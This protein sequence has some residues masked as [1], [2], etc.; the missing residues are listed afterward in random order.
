MSGFVLL[1]NL[2]S[3]GISFAAQ[4][5]FLENGNPIQRGPEAGYLIDTPTRVKI[6][7]SGR[8]DYVIDGEPAGVVRIP[9]AFNGTGT[10]TYARS[11]ELTADQ[12]D[13]YQFQIVLL[14]VNY[15]CEISLNGEFVGAHTGGYTSFSQPL[16]RELL[17]PGSS[18][19]IQISVSNALDPRKS[20]PVRPLVWGQRNYG[21]I[22]RD[23]YIL[24]TPLRS[25]KDIA[26]TT[27]LAENEASA[28]VAVRPTLE[29][30]FP[31]L[32]QAAEPARPVKGLPVPAMY[33]EVVERLT[34]TSVGRSKTTALVR[35]GDGWEEMVLQA[36]IGE[37]RL[38]TPESPDLYVVKTYLVLT[39][40]KV[41]SVLDEYDLGIGIRSLAIEGAEILL[42]GR[43][44]VLKGVNWYEQHPLWGSALPYEQME[45][46]VVLIKNLGANLVRFVGHPPHPY[47]LDLCDRYGLLAMVELPV[48]QVPASILGQEAFVD[49]ATSMT[50]EMVLRDRSHPSVMAWG[51]GD[52]FEAGRMESRRYVEAVASAARLL[53][54]RPLYY[55]TR[56][57][58]QDICSDRAE[59]SAVNLGGGSDLKTFKADLE[60]WKN[61]HSGRPVIVTRL[62][63]EVQQENR[64][65]Y[66]DPFSQEAQARFFLQRL[67]AVRLLGFDGVILGSFNDWRGDR[68]SLSVHSGDP[69]LHSTGLVSS[70]R[71]KRIAYDAVRSVFRGEKFVALPPGTFSSSAPMTYVLAG[72]VILVAV[73]YLYNANR[74]FRESVNRSI[75]NTYNFFADVRDQRIVS[76]AQTTILAVVV[77][78]ATAIVLSSILYHF[79][80][81]RL[82]DNVLGM[83]LLSDGLK[84]A[85]IRLIWNPLRFIGV[86]SGF[87]VAKL[88]IVTLGVLSLRLF[89]RTRIYPFHAYAVTVWSTSPLLLFVPLGMILYRVMESSVY[90]LPSLIGV[91]AVTLWVIVRFL[92]GV[93]IIADIFPS[94]VYI[95]GLMAALLLSGVLYLWLDAARALPEYVV[96]LYRLTTGT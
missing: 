10:V 70:Q 40:G 24:G 18:N 66:S 79:R 45:K 47:M 6:D 7:L 87:V 51:L 86:F 5:P 43:R 14:G 19:R 13:R 83:L 38:W 48:E 96:F 77:A 22:L 59:I 90:V 71:E 37:P 27:E 82:L 88:L 69:W 33:C 17:Q 28:V 35:K 31:E 8:W 68:P 23:V 11:F 36:K 30:S 9:A 3:P 32:S 73:A 20:V 58:Q 89:I 63:L 84:A 29:A 78:L 76:I 4:F 1:I 57:H 34:G 41:D 50:K 64:N 25:I 44:Y 61:A 26:V 46:D 54:S 67:D 42:N 39:S 55:G 80:D 93:S 49:L 81:N 53:D 56:L 74:R 21:G 60:A 16:P 95:A 65:G 92:K 15:T 85:V 91:A 12:L 75:F 2:L 72:F 94:R 62:G 52:E